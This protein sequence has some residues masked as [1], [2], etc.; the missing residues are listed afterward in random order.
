MPGPSGNT[1]EDFAKR[2]EIRLSKDMFNHSRFSRLMDEAGVAAL[3][4]LAPANITYTS[5]YHNIDMPALPERIHAVVCPRGG[6]PTLLLPGSRNTVETF[7]TDVRRYFLY[8]GSEDPGFWMLVDLLKELEIHRER[9]AIEMRYISARDFLRLQKEFPNI[10]FVDAFDI[11]EVT[12]FSKTPAEVE[13]LR[14][15]A[16]LT[17]QAIAKTYAEARISDTE[18]AIGDTMSYTAMQAGADQIAFNFV[19]SGSRLTHGHHLGSPEQLEYETIA[20]CDF[21]AG[22]RGYFSDLARMAYVGKCSQ[23]QK[24]TY[25]QYLEA[26]HRVIDTVKPGM[27]GDSLYQSS[28]KECGKFGLP[29]MIMAGHS[30]GLVVHERP[31]IVPGDFWEIEEGMV[32][33]IETG[34]VLT[35]LDEQYHLEDMIVVTKNGAE[36]LSDQANLDEMVAIE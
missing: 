6:E 16:R 30:I 9:V 17:D 1:P 10:H 27:T 5:G 14:K 20:R 35:D 36:V 22:F 24:D 23:R 11:L 32:M 4:A 26:H 2:G 7:V 21:G 18:K 29:P 12:R 33:C 28:A 13:F 19:A 15:A 8:D 3:V 31:V 25:A 34:G